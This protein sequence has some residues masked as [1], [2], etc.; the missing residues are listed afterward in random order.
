MRTA[1]ALGSNLGDRLSNLR[2]ARKAVIA[3]SSVKPPLISS[4][5][6]ETKPVDC[7]PGAKKFLNAV[8]EFD[9]ENDPS[10][11]LEQLV[12]IEE[13]LG[14]ERDHAKN[15]SRTIDLD[16]LYSGNR[17]VQQKKLQLPHPRLHLRTFVLRPLADIRAELVIPGQIKTVRALLEQLENGGET[18]FVMQDW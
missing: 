3:L 15:A 10:T 2:A 17:R 6:Y 16:L 5:L 7:E 9:Y 13:K 1:V 11:L 8:I 4:A 18:I 12:C 14:R